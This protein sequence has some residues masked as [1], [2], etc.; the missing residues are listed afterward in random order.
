MVGILNPTYAG[1]FGNTTD[2]FL[3]EL[4]KGT[5]TIVLEEIY[6]QQTVTISAGLMTGSLSQA[7]NF[8]NADVQYTLYLNLLN[9]LTSS[10][11]ILIKFDNSWKLYSNMCNVISGITMAPKASLTCKNYTS[12]SYVYLNVSGFISA[13][14]SNQLVF[15]IK[16]RSPG[17]TG[18]YNVG[19]QTA[20]SNGILDSM[21]TTVTLNSTYGDYKMLSIDAIVAQSN[22]PV[23]GT[24]PLELTFFLNYDLPQTNVLTYG[25]FELK[26]FPQIPLPPPLIN[27]VLK[28]YFFNTIPAQTCSWDT[29]NPAYT[30]VI[31]NTPLNNNFQYS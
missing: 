22:V 9:S 6:P 21:T 18:T 29:S 1:V 7:N 11:F 15:S 31:I 28:C 27:G 12:G 20:N 5:T 3:I 25:K 19:I 26:I 14:V 24:G 4:L 13:S 16:V 2:G 10:N 8:R 23:S 17:T 30:K